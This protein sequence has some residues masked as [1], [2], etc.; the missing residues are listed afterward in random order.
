MPLG[1]SVSGKIPSILFVIRAENKNLVGG[2]GSGVS[3]QVKLDRSI[4]KTCPAGL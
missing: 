3:S 1:G 2:P 4:E